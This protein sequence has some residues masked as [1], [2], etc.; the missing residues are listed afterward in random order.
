MQPEELPTSAAADPIAETVAT[1]VTSTPAT[2]DVE[3]P[4]ELDAKPATTTVEPATAA[5]VVVDVP[6]SDSGAVIIDADADRDQLMES[7]VL[8]EEIDEVN[9]VTLNCKTTKYDSK[10]FSHLSVVRT[11]MGPA[12]RTA[13]R[14]TSRARPVAR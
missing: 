8:D 6:D 9:N 7:D 12:R 10:R 2:V 1:E 11:L 4:I 13:W 3:A 5:T 14:A